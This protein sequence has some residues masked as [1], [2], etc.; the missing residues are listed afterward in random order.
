MTGTRQWY[1]ALFKHHLIGCGKCADE[2]EEMC[3]FGFQLLRDA[4]TAK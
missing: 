3:D 2:H 4:L 1:Y